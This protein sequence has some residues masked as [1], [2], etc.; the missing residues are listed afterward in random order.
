MVSWCSAKLRS[1]E[2][3]ICYMKDEVLI[4][5]MNSVAGAVVLR[6]LTRPSQRAASPGMGSLAGRGMPHQECAVHSWL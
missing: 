4:F 5:L 3:E 2:H 6:P 1:W